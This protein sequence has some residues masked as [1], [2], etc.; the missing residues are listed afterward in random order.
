[1]ILLPVELLGCHFLLNG[2]RLELGLIALVRFFKEFGGTDDAITGIGGVVPSLDLYS[3]ALKVLIYGEEVRNFLEHVRVDVGVVPDVGVAR[4]VF[5]DCENLFVEGALV[6]HL[7]E[8]DRTNFVDASGEGGMRD[9]DQD[10]QG[11]TVVAEGRGYEAV[12]AGVVHG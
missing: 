4:V 10:V 1:M 11:I 2:Y 5:A 6:E 7:E 3:L 12:V 9:E 8:A